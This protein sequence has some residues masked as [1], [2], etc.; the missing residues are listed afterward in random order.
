M[1]ICT[2]GNTFPS[3]DELG[4]VVLRFVHAKWRVQSEVITFDDARQR[5][6]IADLVE[7]YTA[8]TT[9]DHDFDAIE[10]HET[11]SEYAETEGAYVFT[12]RSTSR[13]GS[14]IAWPAW[15]VIQAEVDTYPL[16]AT[17]VMMPE[18][19]LRDLAKHFPWLKV[20]IEYSGIGSGLLRVNSQVIHCSDPNVPSY[21]EIPTGSIAV[22][23]NRDDALKRAKRKN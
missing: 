21:S 18:V 2:A 9:D 5:G 23:L 1:A 16:C 22:A 8:A 14:W 10:S 6:L 7:D 11:S 15:Y 4:D 13:S 17:F 3:L 12:Y 19:T 20:S